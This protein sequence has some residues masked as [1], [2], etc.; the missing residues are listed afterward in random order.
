[1]RD[2]TQSAAISAQ[3][4]LHCSCNDPCM[5]KNVYIDAF[6]S[7]WWV[8]WTSRENYNYKYKTCMRFVWF[9]LSWACVRDNLISMQTAVLVLLPK[10]YSK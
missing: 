2:A 10:L 5:C 7:V 8:T 3:Y 4:V 1:M 6:M 9:T